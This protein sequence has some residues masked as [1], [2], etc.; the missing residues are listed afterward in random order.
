YPGQSA[1]GFGISNTAC[2]GSTTAVGGGTFPQA[3]IPVASIQSVNAGTWNAVT[4]GGT[5]VNCTGASTTT[6]T[7]TGCT[8]GSGTWNNGDTVTYKVI[9]D[10]NH[11][12]GMQIYAAL[13]GVAVTNS[14]FT[15][16]ATQCIFLGGMGSTAIAT[17]P[18]LIANGGL[19]GTGG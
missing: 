8:G 5:T 1:D 11:V 18:C 4:I 3:S 6:N 19:P 7:F 12:D 10:G 15:N 2:N 9:N 13:N 16:C 17:S 14:H